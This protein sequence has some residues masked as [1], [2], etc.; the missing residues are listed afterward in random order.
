[1]KLLDLIKSHEN[2]EELLTKDPYNIK[3][4][5]DDG[6]IMFKYNQLSSDFTNP[7]VREARGIIFK[8]ADW[9]CVCHPFD[10]FMNAEEEN[11]D[12]AKIDWKTASCQEKIDGS[13]MKVWYDNGWHISTN[14][15]IDAYKAEI[16][17]SLKYKTFG[18]LFDAA[19]INSNLKIEE[20]ITSSYAIA[21]YLLTNGLK[22]IYCIGTEPLKSEIELCGINIYS[23]EPQAV[24][25]GYNPD[26]KLSDLD[27]LSNIKLSE[28]K[29]IVANKERNYPKE[30]GYIV[31]GAGPIVAAVETLL[32]KETDVIVGK[33]NTTM[34]KIMNIKPENLCI[35]GD[36]YN[37][38]IQM[39]KNYGADGILI[40]KEKKND[41]ICIEELSDLL[42]IWND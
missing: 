22:N 2:W 28:Y 40:T 10:K 24:V 42:E 21:K 3:I 32:N 26:F 18:E 31:P 35:V 9:K 16:A 5:R 34:L 7:I 25:V 14:G 17:N 33:P 41:C 36:S 20:L 19:A 4:S 15:T 27:E 12:L 30:N 39:A 13:L 1:M 8:E 38:D 11:S 6:Y 29:L 37:S 23:K